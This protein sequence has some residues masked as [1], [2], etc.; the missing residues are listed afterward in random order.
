MATFTSD[1]PLSANPASAKGFTFRWRYLIALV[2]VV[3]VVAH[4]FFAISRSPLTDYYVSVDQLLARDVPGS[5]IRV[6]AP[7]V[8]GS[9]NWDAPSRTLTFELQG[10]KGLLPVRYR[11]FAPDTFREGA[12]VIVEGELDGTSAFTA[13]NL[14][15]KCPHAYVPG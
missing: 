8:P 15:V 3:P 6:G 14:L 2:V 5:R 10:D 4:L 13:Y 9:I 1:R 11:G 12:T 7:V